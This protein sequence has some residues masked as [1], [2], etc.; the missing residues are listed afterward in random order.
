M[1]VALDFWPVLAQWPLLLEGA[2]WT[3]GLTAVATLLGS[4]VGVACAWARV[5]GPWALRV[6]AAAYVELIRNTPFIVQLF[7]VFFGLPAAG[8][9]LTPLTASILA[10]TINLGAYATEI[11]RAG[12]QATPR[13]QIEAA[14]SLALTRLQV[15]VHI[16]LPPAL[17]RVWPA[18]TSQIIIVMLGS[19]VCGQIS[20]EELSHAANLIQ[21]RNF[22][23][24]EAYILA[25]LVYLGL[26][27]LVRRVLHWAG[28]RF[29]FGS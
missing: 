16:V 26:A 27:I 29:V 21:S 6:P 4:S 19:A 15:F 1:R 12:I 9:R 10:M 28:Q 20:M 24:F 22:R 2:A 25:T 7:F 8:I 5:S 17:K 23:A 11:V 13:G 3:L 18:L 14:E